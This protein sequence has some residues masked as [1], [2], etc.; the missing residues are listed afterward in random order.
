VGITRNVFTFNYL[1]VLCVF[2]VRNEY[3]AQVI[4]ECNGSFVIGGG[5]NLCRIIQ[6]G[7]ADLILN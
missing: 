7:M 4:K 1:S 6:E 2:A 5:V 3:T